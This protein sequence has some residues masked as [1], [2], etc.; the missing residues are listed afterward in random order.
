[1]NRQ[2]GKKYI[3][4]QVKVKTRDHGQ[5]VGVL[6]KIIAPPNT[7]WKGLVTIVGVFE[8]PPLEIN[9][10]EVEPLIHAYNQEI[11]FSGQ[12]LEALIEPFK[13]SY[14]AS[15]AH[16]LKNRW[17]QIQDEIDQSDRTLSRIQQELR[18]LKSEHLIFEDVYVYYH[19]VKKGRKLFI[20]DEKKKESLSLDGCPFEFE[21]KTEGQW[22]AALYV[23]GLLFET[24]DNE[25]VELSHGSVIRL[26]KAQFDPYRILV[27]ELESPSLLA[28][29]RGLEKLGIGHE[30]SVYCHNSLLIQLLDTFKKQS[31]EGVNFLSYANNDTQ[32]V[33]QHHYEREIKD[34]DSPD[35]TFDRFEFTSDKGERVLT[36][37]A[38]QFS[39]D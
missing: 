20:Y 38:T 35:V 37:Y 13:L 2:Q 30:H 39:N 29:E 34:D 36:T 11:E 21:I 4:K 14:E 7:P 5:Y 28:L 15:I 31:L 1:M 19:I 24:T 16:A 23:K 27:N 8:Y 12:Q 25:E 18:K 22:K 3:G 32:F 9:G 26:N 33:V 17:T 10:E 6:H